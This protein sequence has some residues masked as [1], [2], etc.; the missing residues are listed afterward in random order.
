MP[1]EKN[2]TDSFLDPPLETITKIQEALKPLGYVVHGYKEKRRKT[3]KAIVLHLNYD[4]SLVK[5]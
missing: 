2:K 3:I 4:Y 1:E 5:I